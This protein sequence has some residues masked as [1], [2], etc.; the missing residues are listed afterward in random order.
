MGHKIQPQYALRTEKALRRIEKEIDV[1]REHIAYY[2]KRLFDYHENN[3]NHDYEDTLRKYENLRAERLAGSGGAASGG[4]RIRRFM[5]FCMSIMRGV[6]AAGTAT[7]LMAAIHILLL[8]LDFG[9]MGTLLLLTLGS[10][11]G[12]TWM[13]TDCIL[14]QRRLQVEKRSAEMEVDAIEA[15]MA[16]LAHQYE[17]II[18]SNRK[19]AIT[20]FRKQEQLLRQVESGRIQGES[21]Y[22]GQKG[23]SI[24]DGRLV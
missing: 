1:C 15:K 10:S 22:E 12:L 16:E 3:L 8:G 21:E 19:R 17:S 14:G 7:V 9:L 18:V 4:W 23:A 13:I 2:E 5:S 24:W 6:A 11:I 20:L